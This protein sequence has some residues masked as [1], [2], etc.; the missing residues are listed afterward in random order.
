MA[1]RGGF[2]SSE[3]KNIPKVKLTKNSLKKALRLF[4]YIGPYKG[5]FV[6]GLI[7]LILT[8]V[9]AIVFPRF[10]GLLVDSSQISMERIN[11]MGLKLLILFALQAI[12]SFFRVVL[13][14]NV[15]ENMLLAIRKA[16]Y[17]HLI[18]MPMSFFAQRRVGEINS[19]MSADLA[20]IG[21][22]FTTSIAEFLRQFIIILGGI[23]ALFFTSL[24]LAFLMLAIVPVVAIVAVF[25]GRYIRG[26]SKKVQDKIAESNVIVEE[27]MQGIANVKSFAN[28]FF[29]ILRYTKNINEIKKLAMTGGKARGAFFSFII[30]CLF[31]AIILLIWFAVKLESEGQ[32]SHGDMIQFMLYTVFVGASIGGIAEQ[33]AQIQKAIGATERVMEILDEKNETITLPNTEN[34]SVV[35]FQRLS[36]K[37][38]F[39]NIG[40]TYPSRKEI[41][42]I[43]N[44]SFDAKSGETIAFVGPSG[45]GKSTLTSLIL[46]FYEPDSGTILFD[47]K[48]SS[49]YSLTELRNNMAIVP[50]DVLLF[51]G[52]IRENIAYGKPDASMEEIIEA[53][54][55][56]NAHEFISGFPEQYE[57]IVGERGI[58][59]SGGQRQRVAIARAVLKNPAILIL[60]E[61]TSSLDSESER[62]VQEA[63]DKLMVGR[64]SFVIAHRLST[65]RNADK[66][67]VIDKGTVVEI[68]THIE[69]IEKDNG[70]YK[71]LSKLQFE[72]E[73][74]S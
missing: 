43:K 13:F 73:K 9:T 7:F 2:S 69:L 18:Q 34:F 60:D 42:V 22:T 53:S 38:E 30:F 59:L 19:R 15:T 14:V 23:T 12:F 17:S 37:V 26:F 74:N 6:L 62:L 51:G 71:N 68:G 72:F 29:E 10:M 55:K 39:S 35:P 28:E 66:I 52:T 57:T 61:A 5:Q 48:V 41:E 24:K 3:D 65:I 8:G 50:Q 31:G 58:K 21:D 20:Q 67:I 63:L 46:R 16:T 40:F 4:H 70:L 56:A 32:L 25:F 1:R 11:E 44:I 49:S 45:S 33:Y 64:T 27:T 54:R 36:G 47:G